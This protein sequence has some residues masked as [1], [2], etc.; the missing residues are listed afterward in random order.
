M[1]SKR[2][3]RKRG[4]FGKHRHATADQADRHIHSLS[5]ISSAQ[6]Q[7]YHCR[8]CGGFH[9]GHAMLGKKTRKGYR[10]GS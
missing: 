4:C 2:R 8:E 5:F 9:V 3:Q 6:Y 1:A 10:W 7:S